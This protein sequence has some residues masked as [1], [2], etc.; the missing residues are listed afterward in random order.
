MLSYD[1]S[2]CI[3]VVNN[4]KK[5]TLPLLL[6]WPVLAAADF[7]DVHL[8]YNWDQQEILS[9]QQAVAILRQHQVKLAVV[10]STPSENAL[11]LREA[12][13]D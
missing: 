7:A 6:Y 10:F 11:R 13:G 5:L 4:D 3:T 12:G 1:K 2:S 9:A 8:H